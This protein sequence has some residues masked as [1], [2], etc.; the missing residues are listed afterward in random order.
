MLPRL[1]ALQWTLFIAF[2]AFYGFA[3]FALT[4]DYYLRHPLTPAAGADAPHQLPAG[5]QADARALG[6]RMRQALDGAPDGSEIGSE[7]DLGSTDSAALAA[8]ADRLFVAR[9][10]DEAIPVYQRVLELEPDDADTR[11]D[12]GLALHYTGRSEEAIAMLRKGAKE[13]PAFQRI[14]LSLGFVALQAGD[15]AQARDALERAE[16]I[17]PSTEVGREAARLLGVLN[18]AEAP[19]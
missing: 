16:A 8:A 14:W 17:A 1:S 18:E 2:L 15:I 3:V 19:S 12:L 7:I 11:N 5:Q 10:F 6:A 9:R 4:R 13:A